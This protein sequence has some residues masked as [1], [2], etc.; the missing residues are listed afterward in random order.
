MTPSPE[1]IPVPLGDRSYDI[2]MGDGV[3]GSAGAH[4][5]PLLRTPRIAV[6]CDR[7]VEDHARTL[8]GS[9]RDVGVTTSL[10]TLPAGEETKSVEHLV[11]IWDHLCAQKIGRDGAVAAVGGGVAGDLVGFAAASYLR[12]V[13]FVQVPTSLLAMV[14]S[15]VGGKTGINNDHGKNL[16]G[17]FWQPRLVL[18]D[19]GVLRTLP[20]GEAISALA[21]IIKYGVIRDANFFAWLEE[22][23]DDLVALQPAAVAHAVRRSCEIK[24]EVVGKDERE[25]GLREILNFGHTVGHAIEN[26]AEYGTLRHGEAIAI[27]MVAESAMSLG[28]QPRWTRREHD[29]LVRL[30][31]RAGL[32]TRIPPG[33]SLTVEQL[34]AAA[35]SDK[36]VRAGAIRYVVPVEMG[37]VESMKFENNVVEPFLKEV[38]AIGA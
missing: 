10:M 31:E 4:V 17:A 34:L 8:I 30:V 19:I 5:A 36:K 1:R 25:S 11:A 14:D 32:P 21:E 38:G 23:I 18:A 15:S 6:V 12:G 20:R 24:A 26:A 2:L 35:S 22:R 9:L 27:G 28:R 13:D 3:L 29:R 33:L 7:H 16:I 37:V